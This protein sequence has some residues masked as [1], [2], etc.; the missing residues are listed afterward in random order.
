MWKQKGEISNGEE[1]INDSALAKPLV[2]MI[3]LIATL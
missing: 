3:H 1:C 2:A